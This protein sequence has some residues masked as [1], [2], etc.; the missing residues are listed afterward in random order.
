MSEFGKGLTY[1]LGLFLA[2]DERRTSALTDCD[3]DWGLWFNGAAD[4][5][6]DLQIPP[7]LPDALQEDLLSFQK[8]CLHWRL[9]DATKADKIWA[10]ATAKCLLMRID[11]H[12][13]VEVE[14]GD[15]E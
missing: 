15:W 14:K 11:E 12:F 9:E 7:T 10:T 6:F 13:G 5:L 8:Q 4:H 2:H 3:P 1:C